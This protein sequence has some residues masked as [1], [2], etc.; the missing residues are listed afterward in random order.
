M[1]A[2]AMM[3]ISVPASAAEQSWLLDV[4]G[5]SGNPGAGPWGTVVATTNGANEIDVTVTLTIP[6]SVGFVNTGNHTPFAFSLSDTATAAV[7]VLTTGFSVGSPP[8][9]PDP[10][11]GNFTNGIFCSDSSSPSG[12]GSGGNSPNPGPLSFKIVDSSFSIANPIGFGIFINST[13]GD[14]SS[15][16]AADILSNGFTGA[17]GTSN[18]PAIPEP[19]TYAMMLVGFGLL[20]FVARRRRQSLGNTVPA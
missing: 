12:C 6:P 7:T 9:F 11:F 4:W 18:T 17:V 19:E 10:S 5:G 13:G 15:P 2:A 1:A 20:G 14:L 3:A 8:P 16:F